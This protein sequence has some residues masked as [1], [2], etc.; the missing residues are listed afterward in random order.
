MVAAAR[1]AF[2]EVGVE[3]TRV[4]DVARAAGLSKASFY[5]YFQSKDALF[6]ELVQAFFRECQACADERHEAVTALSMRI[7]ACEASDWATRSERFQTFSAL[8][9]RYTLRTL[10]ILWSWRD[11]LRCLLEHSTS[12]QRELVDSLI[13]TTTSSLTGRL[14]EAM[15]AGYLRQDID[16]EL[17]SEILI[18]AY[19]Q[20]GRK[21]FSRSRPPDFER[22][23]R[24]VEIVLNEGLRP[25]EG[26]EAP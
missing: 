8:D 25:R 14:A 18:G 10:E 6:R 26:G 22:W 17:A 5:V 16:P 11:M 13:H 23:A 20:L 3:A 24:S 7:G 19:L 4:E 21:M 1:R 12:G 15:R 2:A 9:H